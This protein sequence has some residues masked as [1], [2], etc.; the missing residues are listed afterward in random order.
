MRHV[1]SH[2]RCF[3]TN[4]LD[5]SEFWMDR[6]VSL[7]SCIKNLNDFVHSKCQRIHTCFDNLKRRSKSSFTAGSCEQAIKRLNNWIRRMR[8][9]VCSGIFLTR[10]CWCPRDFVSFFLK[11]Y[12][13]SLTTRW[14]K[15]GKRIAYKMLDTLCQATDGHPYLDVL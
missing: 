13:S 7:G 14:G 4:F 6:N 1:M 15:I 2:Y 10:R 12:S 9:L 8:N 11:C 5:S 3:S